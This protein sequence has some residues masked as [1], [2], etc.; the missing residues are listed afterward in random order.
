[1]KR[2]SRPHAWISALPDK[3]RNEVRAAMV[4]KTFYNNEFI[5]KQGDP[6][7]IIYEIQEGIVKAT[8]TSEEG[9]TVLIAAWGKGDCAGETSVIDNGT[10]ICDYQA[11]GKTLL[12]MLTKKKFDQLREKHPEINKT[13]LYFISLQ[14]RFAATKHIS[15]EVLPLKEKLISTILSIFFEDKKEA[16]A[17]LDISQGDLSDMVG[18]A[19]QSVN[20]ELHYLQNNNLITL[21]RGKIYIPDIEAL[22]NELGRPVSFPY[23]QNT[24]S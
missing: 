19:R 1:M 7:T 11:V 23:P 4:M 18:A 15:S 14:F 3:I 8:S 12:G 22:E 2:L 17:C 24:P 21:E 16:M 5:H 9:K 20:K 10:R 13:L 6:A